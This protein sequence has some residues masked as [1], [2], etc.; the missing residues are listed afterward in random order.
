MESVFDQDYLPTLLKILSSAKKSVDVLAYSFA[1]GSAAG[2]HNVKSAPF[3]IATKLAELAQKKI[4]VRFFTEGHRDTNER[5]RVT[6]KFL[7]TAGVKVKYGSTHAKGIAVDGKTILFGSTNL[8]HQSITK[9]HEANLL[10]TDKKLAFGFN[11]YFDHLWSGGKHGEAILPEPWLPDGDFEETLIDLMD[12]SKKTI[13]FSIYF[14]N[15]REI[16]RA[17]IRAHERGVKIKGFIHQHGS[18]ALSYIFANRRTV[19]RL[20]EKGISDLYWGKHT[21]FSHSKYLVVDRK[22]I[23]ISTAN[24]LQEDVHIHPQLSLHVQDTKL[25]KKFLQHLN[26][27]IKFAEVKARNPSL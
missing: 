2:K 6:A 23:I 20:K 13:E 19:Q 4:Q 21:L 9:N 3:E 10:I 1:M 27:Q 7:K 18:F 26:H 25:A 11:Q 14:F 22:E 8:T 15:H 16:E 12:Q 5:N 17:L 24:W